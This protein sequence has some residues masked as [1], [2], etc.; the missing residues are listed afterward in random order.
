MSITKTRKFIER[1]GCGLI[2]SIVVGVIMLL[3]IVLYG[4]SG[5]PRMDEQSGPAVFQ[6]GDLEVPAQAVE[7]LA[8]AAAR[9]PDTVAKRT[10]LAPYLSDDIPAEGPE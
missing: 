4:Q 9:N 5:A 7:L 6:V 10:T 8:E 3:G 2:V 1:S